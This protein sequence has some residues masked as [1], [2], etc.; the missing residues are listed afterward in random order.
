MEGAGDS[1]LLVKAVWS[2][3]LVLGL[4]FIAERVSTRIAGIVSGAP[5]NIVLVY[6]FVGIERGTDHIVQSTPHSMAAFTATLAFVLGY[7][8]AASRIVFLASIS[9]ALVGLTAFFAVA[10]LL[11]Q[12][13]FS[14]AG[15]L[16]VTILTLIFAVWALRRVPFEPIERPVRYTSRLILF[17]GATAAFLVLLVIAIAQSTGPQWTGLM[18]GFPGTLL[19]TLLILHATY[20]AAPTQ[21]L[22]RNIPLGLGS[23]LIFVLCVRVTYPTLGLLPGT[24]V[25]VL[26]SLAYLTVIAYLPASRANTR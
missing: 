7:F 11:A 14:I 24:L 26:P 8:W 9:S 23:I 12:F 2:V 1:T 15:A 6:V 10:A 25:A 18:T 3:A 17:R 4:A 22:L 13:E 20:A 16:W 19:P 21:A 5:L